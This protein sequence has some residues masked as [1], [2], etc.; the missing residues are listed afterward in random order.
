VNGLIRVEASNGRLIITGH[1][2]WASILMVL[3]GAVLSITS[4]QV[5][6]FIG[7]GFIAGL[8]IFFQWL[9]T[10]AIINAMQETLKN[11]GLILDDPFATN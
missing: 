7:F 8:S 6:I 4:T 10:R 1:I 9:M 11:E 3:F 2:Y 5:F